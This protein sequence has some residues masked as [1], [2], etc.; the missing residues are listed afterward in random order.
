MFASIDSKKN[1]FCSVLKLL[2][3]VVHKKKAYAIRINKRKYTWIS[4][5]F[6]LDWRKREYI[7]KKL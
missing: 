1:L 5:W 2:V 3:N 7:S 4:R 6:P